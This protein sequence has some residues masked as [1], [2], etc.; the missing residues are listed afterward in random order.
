MEST[1]D[2]CDRLGDDVRVL[3]GA[4][5]HLGGTPWVALLVADE[6]GVVVLAA[7]LLDV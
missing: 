4:L 2:L 7:D 6:D 1:C 3:P 5:V